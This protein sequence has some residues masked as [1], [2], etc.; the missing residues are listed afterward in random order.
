MITSTKE[1]EQ[2]IMQKINKVRSGEY[3]VIAT[4]GVK[5]LV[6]KNWDDSEWQVFEIVD[7]EEVWA[8]TCETLK[9]SK[10]WIN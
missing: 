10:K 7:G 8:I 9:E 6:R 1:P 4:D 2:N 5:F 3:S